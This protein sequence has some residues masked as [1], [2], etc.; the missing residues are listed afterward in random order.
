VTLD[1]ALSV[2]LMFSA[3]CYLA[4]GMRLIAAKRDVGTIPIGLLL[5]VIAFW[6]VGGA[7]E[8][9]STTFYVFSI[10]R[11]CHFVGTAFLPVVAYFSFR[12]YT[13]RKSSVHRVIIMLII[14]IVSIVLAATN[15]FHEFMWY[16]PIANAAGEFLTRPAEWG[17]WFLFVHAPYSYAV[18]GAA[19]LSLMT[20]SSAVARAHR[21]GLFLLVAAC[22]AP[23]SATFAYD[24]GVG[25]DTVSFV[26]II[27]TAMLPIYA[28]LILAEQIIDFT[29]LAYE[30]VFQN[31]QDPV[32]VVDDQGRII[33]LN[34]GAEALLD[35]TETS[36]LMEPLSVVLGGDSPE[37][38]EALESGEPRN[39]LTA[40]GRYLHVQ[41][42]DMASTRATLPDGRV[43]M[44]RDVSDVE[45]AQA[46]V[47]AS[48]AMLRMLID[49]SVNG[50]IRLRWTKSE[51]ESEEKLR[52]VFANAAAAR[53]LHMEGD[54][55]IDCS[56]EQIVRIATNAM[57]ADE[58]KAIVGTFSK[59]ARARES[60]DTEIQHQSNG[61]AKWLR[62][63]CQRFGTDIALTFV[64]I[65]DSKAKVEH[66][67]SIALSDPLTG[68]L[69][70][71][72]FERDASM[73]LTE[74]PDD[75]SGALLFI[76]LNDFKIINDT[77]GHEVGDELLTIASTRL[78]KSLRSCDII[79]RP[80]GDE[81]VALVPDVTAEVAEQLARRLTKTLEKP[82]LIGKDKL[83][84]AAS[85][86]LA[87]YPDN[88]ST[89]T[90]LLREADQAMYR[91][92]DRCRGVTEIGTC[93]LLEKAM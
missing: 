41:V 75:A 90:G 36:A 8:L 50:I 91:A 44:F 93:D 71:R 49:H 81:F 30:T 26:P 14:P 18:I 79:G 72:G 85:I 54:D 43:L 61:T 48:E 33:G 62:M 19:M 73:R 53:F 28:W 87:L 42:S 89:L 3:A 84:C 2:I 67:E 23:L 45:E 7:I 11:T 92:K 38:F 32:V 60:V 83:D 17:R 10:G 52:C 88:A 4:L 63:I 5:V 66:M 27:L 82:Y 51:D 39:M 35:I 24:L 86:G 74:S 25:P 12:E 77:Y 9:M 47:R 15:Y 78:K 69:N 34:R 20:H 46:E 1:I 37:I 68:V 29:P 56:G 22:I 70:R 65:T 55:L 58:A 16:V 64:D 76:D 31:M 21:R 13:G 40:T 57:D 59:A 6:V 80:G